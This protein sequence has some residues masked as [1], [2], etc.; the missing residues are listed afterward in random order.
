MVHED[1][2]LLERLGCI[3]VAIILVL[4]CLALWADFLL[5]NYPFQTVAVL[6][7]L[8]LLVACI[9]LIRKET[10]RAEAAKRRAEAEKKA[11]IEA[12]KTP[13]QRAAEAAQRAANEAQRA[14]REQ[15]VRLAAERQERADAVGATC[16]KCLEAI[17]V[18]ATICPYCRTRLGSYYRCSQCKMEVDPDARVC[19]W[20]HTDLD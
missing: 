19:P 17:H 5:K 12:A 3:A 9:A 11:A 10:R 14:A 15:Q 18:R 2:N 1:K 20:C 13:E 7:A 8:V 4:L 6:V 16:P